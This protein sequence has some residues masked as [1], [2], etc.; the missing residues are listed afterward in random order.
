MFNFN[1]A[2]YWYDLTGD[3]KEDLVIQ[4]N[5]PC[6]ENG[7]IIKKIIPEAG[8][9]QCLAKDFD[10]L[11]FD[12]GGMSVGNDC[13]QRFCRYILDDAENHTNRYYVM[14]SMFTEEAM[15]DAVMDFGKS[16]PF[17]VFLSVNK[18]A[19]WLNKHKEMFME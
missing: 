18:F 4:V 15:K 17:N 1:K 19:K 13:L 3:W 6:I 2:Y 11:F 9:G 5:E 7:I 14:V 10:I 16:K 8:G 12:W